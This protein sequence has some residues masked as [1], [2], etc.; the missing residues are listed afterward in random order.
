MTKN[1]SK[2]KP[3]NAIIQICIDCG[4]IDAYE[5]DNHVC[6]REYQ[7]ERHEHESR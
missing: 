7:N 6:N 5:G 2:L 3:L 4:K 1:K